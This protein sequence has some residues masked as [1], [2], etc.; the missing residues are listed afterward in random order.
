MFAII[1][2]LVLLMDLVAV[3]DILGR[4][5]PDAVKLAWIVIVLLLPVLGALVYLLVGRYRVGQ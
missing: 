1:S 4:S 3:V 5:A 2:V